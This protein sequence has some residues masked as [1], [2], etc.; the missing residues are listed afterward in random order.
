MDVFEAIKNRRSVRDYDADKQV[1]QELIE[2]IVEAARWAPSAGNRQP[3]EIVV[4]TDKEKRERM[5]SVSGYAP[6]LKDSPVALVVC[7]N[8][9]KYTKGYENAREFY[10]PM[11]ASAAIQNMMLA[12]HALGLGSCWDSVFDKKVVREL[13]DIPEDV[14]P[15]AII[16]LGY[17]SRAPQP[18]RRRPI[19]EYLRWETYHQKAV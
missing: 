5:A 4:V 2:K 17:P 14:E 15:F 1:P 18:P 19:E 6:Y 9:K 7:V 11:D 13:V 12:A 16:A 8:Q 10:T 3:V